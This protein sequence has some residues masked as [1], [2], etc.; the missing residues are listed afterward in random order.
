MREVSQNQTKSNKTEQKQKKE[1]IKREDEKIRIE[2]AIK[3]LTES[4]D[5]SDGKATK[6][7]ADLEEKNKL[8]QKEEKKK[9]ELE[10]EIAMINGLKNGLWIGNLSYSKYFKSLATMRSNLVKE[11]NC[12]TSLELMLVDRI[13]ANYWRAMKY[14]TIFNRLIEKEDG[15]YSFDQLKVNIIK[16]FNKGID[17]ANRQLNTN[18]ILLKELKQPK[19]NVKVNTENAFISQNQQFNV[20]KQNDKQDENNENINPK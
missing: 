9:G 13:V 6:E 19:L 20:N 11:Y 12:K 15:G 16:E 3:P 10:L 1:I 7:Y 2:R 14:D 4:I 8:T 5:F 18:I 17:L